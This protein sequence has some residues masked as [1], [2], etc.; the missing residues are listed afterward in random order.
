MT[1]RSP[2]A[3][4]IDAKISKL[5]IARRALRKA[6]RKTAKRA[7][8]AA[9]V[10]D[11]GYAKWIHED[12]LTCIACAIEGAPVGVGPNPIEVA[13]QKFNSTAAGWQGQR[14]GARVSDWQ[15]VP[16][17]RWHHQGAPNACDKA[18]RKFWDRLRVDAVALCRDLY[19]AFKAQEPGQPVIDRYAAAKDPNP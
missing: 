9:S 12:G 3:R 2:E 11:P 8:P 6:E 5:Q 19:A 18:Q 13:H 16:L 17:C 4:E 10:K 15:S 7:K 14:V 1:I